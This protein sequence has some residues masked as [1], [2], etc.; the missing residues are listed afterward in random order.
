MHIGYVPKKKITNFFRTAAGPPPEALKAL[1]LDIVK[2]LAD[3]EI[4]QQLD[5]QSM[6]VMAWPP[7]E[8]A[9]ASRSEIKHW[10]QAVEESGARLG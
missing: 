8:F 5:R 7:A 1:H 3:P 2:V 9:V 10:R 4:N 6:D